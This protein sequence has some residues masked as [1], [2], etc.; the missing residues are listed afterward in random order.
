MHEDE[1]LKNRQSACIASAS[2]Q[3]RI[4]NA[5]FITN[6]FFD[7]RYNGTNFL[8]VII[9]YRFHRALPHVSHRLFCSF[10]RSL[11]DKC[12]NFIKLLIRTRTNYS[13]SN[14]NSNS[15]PN[16]KV[17]HSLSSRTASL[18]SFEGSDLSFYF[19]EPL[20][21]FRGQTFFTRGFLSVP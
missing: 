19:C 4:R 18:I 8:S 11:T 16:S 20:F 14:S 12:E 17:L 9:D 13:N 15:G 21:H 7:F 3:P 10:S 1:L 6:T 5:S 2:P